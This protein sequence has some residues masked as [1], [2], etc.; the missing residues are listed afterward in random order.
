MRHHRRSLDLTRTLVPNHEHQAKYLH[1]ITRNA[2]FAGTDGSGKDANDSLNP[3]Q[4]PLEADFEIP[5]LVL[6]VQ[7][8]FEEER[9][10]VAAAKAAAVAAEEAAIAAEQLRLQTEAAERA[11]SDAK[12]KAALAAGAKGKGKPPTGG[13][14]SSIASSRAPAAKPKTP[15][16]QI[17]PKTPEKQIKSKTP[18]NSKPKTPTANPLAFAAKQSSPKPKTPATALGGSV[19]PSTPSASKLQ[20][21]SAPKPA[22]PKEPAAGSSKTLKK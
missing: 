1:S 7:G 9:A 17:K 11:A 12:A 20:T 18:E 14:R 3:V 19:K 22:S 8:A 15:E 2:N 10:C 6:A 4:S 21:A 5:P 13:A 16:K